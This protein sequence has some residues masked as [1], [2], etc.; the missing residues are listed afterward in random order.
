MCFVS[1]SFEHSFA[2]AAGPAYDNE[3]LPWQLHALQS[4]RRFSEDRLK[5]ANMHS[6]A[7][8][9]GNTLP[10][11]LA[12][13][14]DFHVYSQ[15]PT[16]GQIKLAPRDTR[17]P[18]FHDQPKTHDTPAAHYSTNAPVFVEF[19][20]CR[21]LPKMDTFGTCD[22]F[23]TCGDWSTEC[24]KNTQYALLSMHH[25]QSPPTLTV[26]YLLH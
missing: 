20:R 21:D 22:C 10:P 23:I 18:V 4:L 8:D 2:A 15:E 17:N 25:P 26:H 24:V 6:F 14:R 11:A 7:D 3:A 13:S 16:P 9:F 19:L 12:W 1:I 5:A